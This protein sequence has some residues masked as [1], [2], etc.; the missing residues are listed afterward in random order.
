MTNNVDLQN[1]P[2][3]QLYASLWDMLEASD[4]VKASV[5][6]GNRGKYLGDLNGIKESGLPADQTAVW[7]E[8]HGILMA[9]MAADSRFAEMVVGYGVIISTA[10]KALERA[11]NPLVFE[12]FRALNKWRT[13]TRTL[14]YGSSEIQVY[15]V[16]L[17]N[18]NA[19]T[20]SEKG[21]RGLN[22]WAGVWP[23]RVTLYIPKNTLLA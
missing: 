15:D 2:L 6:I 3:S 13:T 10:E 5:A 19:M 23:V 16:V 21:P 11:F 14:T 8:A 22:G 18:L 9:N 20:S 17:E 7:I 1:D 4:Q 12:I